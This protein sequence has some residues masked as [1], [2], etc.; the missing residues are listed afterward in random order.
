MD[1]YLNLIWKI[2]GD[3]G[4]RSKIQISAKDKSTYYGMKGK[5]GSWTLI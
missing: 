5:L 2:V 1:L 3:L 4:I